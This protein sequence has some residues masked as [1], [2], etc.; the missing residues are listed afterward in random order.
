M[1]K[2][3]S[4]ITLA[5][6]AYLS[7]F[8]FGLFVSLVLRIIYW[9]L[10]SLTA[11][12][13]LVWLLGGSGV[14][15]ATFLV[16]SLLVLLTIKISNWISP[17]EDGMRFRVCGGIVAGLYILLLLGLLLGFINSPSKLLVGISY[18]LSVLFG[19]FLFGMSRS[20]IKGS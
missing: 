12:I 7:I 5:V 9:A 14:L 4:Y 11:A 10:H 18:G 8:L 3:F 2:L 6:C 16:M 15:F 17:S 1:R 19:L 13:V 20:E